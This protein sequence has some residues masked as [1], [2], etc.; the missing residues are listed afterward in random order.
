MIMANEYK[1]SYTA[2]DIN[3]RLGK[4]DEIDSL[5]NLVG[6]TS[7]ADQISNAIE[8]IEVENY[9]HPSTHPA[10]MITGLSNVA[11]SGNYEDLINKP[12]IPSVSGL[13]T[14]SYV[15]E[16]IANA[17]DGIEVDIEID[18]E[19]SKAGAAADAKAVGDALANVKI[20][21]DSTLQI[22]GAAADSKVTG[23][24]ITKLNTLVGTTPV[25]DQ[26]AEAIIDVYVQDDEPVDAP[27]GSIWID[28]DANGAST[29]SGK[30]SANVYVIDAKTTDV[31]NV[32]FSQYAVGDV[33]VVTSS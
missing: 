11:T 18:A 9:E 4:V 15:Q 19:L 27:I 26:I 12:T 33:V 28:T 29:T 21:T 22:S 5:K 14:E 7:V 20:T 2:S 23:D 25:A 1:L 8:N 30:V 10:S 16:E 17:I 13:A 24:A 31:T 32:D 6:T 3:Q